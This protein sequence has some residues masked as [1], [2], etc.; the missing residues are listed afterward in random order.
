MQPGRRYVREKEGGRVRP[1]KLKRGKA[2]VSKGHQ[3]RPASPLLPSRA[4]N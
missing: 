3:V 4:L 2:S 1:V